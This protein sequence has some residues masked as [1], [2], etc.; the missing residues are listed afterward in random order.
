PLIVEGFPGPVSLTGRPCSG[1]GTRRAPL[2]HGPAASA[3]AW[4]RIIHEGTLREHQRGDA[5]PQPGYSFSFDLL[6]L[7]DFRARDFA[8]MPLGPPPWLN[9]K[10]V[11]GSRGLGSPLRPQAPRHTPSSP[12]TPNP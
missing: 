12:S 11:V 10:E 8:P 9:G 3:G 4:R 7:R 1:G 2:H 6:R 5:R